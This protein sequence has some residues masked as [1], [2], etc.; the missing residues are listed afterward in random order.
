MSKTMVILDLDETLV[1]TKED[2][3]SLYKL[4]LCNDESCLE[5]RERVYIL[6]FGEPAERYWGIARPRYREFL[7]FLFSNFDYVTVWSAGTYEYVHAVVD[8]LFRGLRKPDLIY[9]RNDCSENEDGK[10]FKPISQICD[11]MKVNIKDAIIIDDNERT[12]SE[13]RANAVHIPSFEPVCDKVCIGVGDDKL[14]RIMNWIIRMKAQHNSLKGIGN[15][16]K[17]KIF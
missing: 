15:V 4:D 14:Q 11:R 17:S 9:T 6:E 7:K 13:N 3:E 1:S 12:F 10:I 8:Y 5:T 2:M 16:D